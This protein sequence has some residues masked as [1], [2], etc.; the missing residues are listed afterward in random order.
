ME[1]ENKQAIIWRLPNCKNFSIVR[2]QKYLGK[3]LVDRDFKTFHYPVFFPSTTYGYKALR[4][5]IYMIKYNNIINIIQYKLHMLHI[6]FEKV[7][8]NKDSF[9]GSHTTILFFSTSPNMTPHFHTL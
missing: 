4:K 3:I 8:S 2:R 1:A 9:G 5:N 7:D 6:S